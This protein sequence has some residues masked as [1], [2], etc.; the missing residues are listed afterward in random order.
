MQNIEI[1]HCN[2]VT[3]NDIDKALHNGDNLTDIT[4]MFKRVQEETA[5]ST[6]CGGCYEKILETISELMHR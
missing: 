6:K 5:C 3:V 2:N 1:C 4:E